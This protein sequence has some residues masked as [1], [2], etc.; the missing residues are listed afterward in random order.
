MLLILIQSETARGPIDDPNTH[1]ELT[2]IHE[3]MTLDH[4][5]LHLALIQFTSGLKMTIFAGLIAT[6]LNPF[7]PN[8]EMSLSVM[9]SLAILV[10]TAIVVGLVESLVARLRMKTIPKYIFVAVAASTLV[11]L[12][13]VV[14]ELRGR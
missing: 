5:G 6:L 1:L 2:M 10:I 3:V 11:L 12:I 13:T 14:Q 8:E 9:T 7:S 4:C